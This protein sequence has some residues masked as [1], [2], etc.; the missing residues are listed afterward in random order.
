M[1]KAIIL[2]LT[3]FAF[4]LTASSQSFNHLSIGVDLGTDGV[5]LE[6]SAPIGKRLILRA[7]YG[8]AAPEPERRE[9]PDQPGRPVQVRGKLA[10]DG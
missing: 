1:K 3:F 10:A 7:G 8:A 4:G 9:D 6:L 2:I 5:G